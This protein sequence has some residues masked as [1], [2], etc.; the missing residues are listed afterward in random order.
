MIRLHL[1][2]HARER[3]DDGVVEPAMEPVLVEEPGARSASRSRANLVWLGAEKKASSMAGTSWS[4]Q[5]WGSMDSMRANDVRVELK[6]VGWRRKASRRVG[7]ESEG[8][9]AE[10]CAGK[11]S[12]KE[13]RSPRRR[14][15]VVWGPA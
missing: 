3:A 14:G 7:I 1:L 10:R 8:P 5:N 15:A 4:T 2:V 12:L 11:K 9:W 6:G 13:R